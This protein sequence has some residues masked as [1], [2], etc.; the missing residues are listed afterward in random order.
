MNIRGVF[1]LLITTSQNATL[2]YDIEN[3]NLTLY[4]ATS[5]LKALHCMAEF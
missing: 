4:D 1:E 5:K 3:T 2:L